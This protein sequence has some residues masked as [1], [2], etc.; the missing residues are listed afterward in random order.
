VHEDYHHGSWYHIP[1]AADNGADSV[2]F[3]DLAA[4]EDHRLLSIADIDYDQSPA[5]GRYPQD[6]R[7]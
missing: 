6:H 1:F 3:V 7:M 5:G 4:V 2:D